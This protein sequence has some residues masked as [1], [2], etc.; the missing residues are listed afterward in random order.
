MKYFKF[1][2]VLLIIPFVFHFSEDD[3]TI[4]ELRQAKIKYPIDTLKL[5]NE[6]KNYRTTLLREECLQCGKILFANG[7]HAEFWFKTHHCT[8]DYGYTLFSFPDGQET[9]MEGYFCC[10]VYFHSDIK[11]QKDLRALIKKYGGRRP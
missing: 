5:D 11:T 1:L 2:A 3:K 4:E 6:Y 9:I 10:D 7:R 8:N